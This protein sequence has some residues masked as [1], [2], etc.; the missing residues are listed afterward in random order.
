MQVFS[1]LDKIDN[2]PG[3]HFRLLLVD[4]EKEDVPR[5]GGEVGGGGGGL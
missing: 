1:H 5:T 4:G 2:W 3:R